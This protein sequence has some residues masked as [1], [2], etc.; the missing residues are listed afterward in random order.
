MFFRRCAMGLLSERCI[1][2]LLDRVF[3]VK[4]IYVLLFSEIQSPKR[5]L[6]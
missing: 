6:N 1:V 2:S 5:H 3:V 4:P